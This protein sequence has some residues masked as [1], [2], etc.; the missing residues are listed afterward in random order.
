MVDCF[1]D[2]RSTNGFDYQ[3]RAVND[4]LVLGRTQSEII[5]MAAS[6]RFQRHMDLIRSKF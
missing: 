6:L 4:D 3:I 5:P 2:G 1:E